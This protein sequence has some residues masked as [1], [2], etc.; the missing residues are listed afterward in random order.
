MHVKY[1][2]KHSIVIIANRMLDGLDVGVLMDCISL[3]FLCFII[4]LHL[5]SLGCG[6]MHFARSIGWCMFNPQ[7]I[8]GRTITSNF[9]I[10]IRCERITHRRGNRWQKCICPSRICSVRNFNELTS[11]RVLRIFLRNFTEIEINVELVERRKMLENI[12]ITFP[13]LSGPAVN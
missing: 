12:S 8:M 3:W 6:L 11:V 10:K 7:H 5:W 1:A 13:R 4:D 9:L 2:L